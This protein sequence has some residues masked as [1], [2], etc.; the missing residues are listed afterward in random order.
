MSSQ[1]LILSQKQGLK[2]SPRQIQFLHFLQFNEAELEQEIK[3]ELEENPVLD[4]EEEN[5]SEIYAFQRK[6]QNN[7]SEKPLT[8]LENNQ[9]IG[10]D[11]IAELKEGFRYLHL[12]EKTCGIADFILDSVDEKGYLNYS[13]GELEDILSFGMNA[14]VDKNEIAEVLK[15]VK[16]LEPSGVGCRDLQ[17]FLFFQAKKNNKSIV[18]LEIIGHH[19][20]LLSERKFDEICEQLEISSLALKS[21]LAELTGLKPYPLHGFEHSV[22]QKN[23]T[24][25]PEYKVDFRDGEL[26]YGTLSKS[27]KKLVFNENYG[28]EFKEKSDKKLHKFLMEKRESAAW[29]M[30]AVEEREHTMNVCISAV[31][32][33][34][35]SYFKSGSISDLKPMVLKDVAM[36]TGKTISTLSRVTSQK[37]VQTHFGLV[38][39]KSLFTEAIQ[40]NDGQL[41]SNKEVQ[42]IVSK[43]VSDENKQKPLTDAEICRKLA[44]DG[45]SLTRRTITKYRENMNIPSSK[46]RR[47]L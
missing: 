45:F 10:F 32:K 38:P 29:F 7:S 5:D 11:I 23:E 25:I 9:A 31:V 12:P 16:H 39:M 44:S 34:Q 18:L 47:A 27:G 35:E 8:F 22:I 19:F 46:L 13:L 20:E 40:K 28:K 14:F 36:L 24:I 33:L 6:P 41:I 37:Y 43:L 26:I 17:D 30:Q 42:E 15:K 2:I 4:F 1:K 21:V 3:K